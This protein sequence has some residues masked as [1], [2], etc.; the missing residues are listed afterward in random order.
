MKPR[1]TINLTTGFY[2]RFLDMEVADIR[3]GRTKVVTKLDTL[4]ELILRG[5]L[6]DDLEFKYDRKRSIK[7]SLRDLLTIVSQADGKLPRRLHAS[8]S[9]LCNLVSDDNEENN[10]QYMS[11]SFYSVAASMFFNHFPELRIDVDCRHDDI[12][13]FTFDEF[14]RFINRARRDPEFPRPEFIMKVEDEVLKELVCGFESAPE[15]QVRKTL[16]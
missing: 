2:E 9:D 13:K 6:V 5:I 1:L 12:Y 14:K 10:R 15:L 7:Y 8:L 3:E 16:G 11:A 4:A